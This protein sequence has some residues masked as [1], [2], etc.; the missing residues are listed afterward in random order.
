VGLRRSNYKNKHQKGGHLLEYSLVIALISALV[1]G[2][3][4]FLGFSIHNSFVA[5]AI[6]LGECG[7]PVKFIA[8]ICAISNGIRRCYN[9]YVVALCAIEEEVI[10][11]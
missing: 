4:K 8:E 2:S 7:E 1:G 9:T 3:V 11:K 5:S 10:K 6:E